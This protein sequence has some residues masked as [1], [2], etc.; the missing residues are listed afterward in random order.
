MNSPF[1]SPYPQTPTPG[2]SSNAL[3][4]GRPPLTSLKPFGYPAQQ[5]NINKQ[6][7][8]PTPHPLPRKPHPLTQVSIMNSTSHELS[9][10]SSHESSLD[11][12]LAEFERNQHKPSNQTNHHQ[13]RYSTHII[14]QPAT[15][16][17]DEEEEGQE[18]E[19]EEED[20]DMIEDED[21]TQIT[22]SLDEEVSNNTD[23][24]SL[25][26]GLSSLSPPGIGRFLPNHR[27]LSA[28]PMMDSHELED[29]LSSV[30]RDFSRD[31]SALSLS[32]IRR[33][34]APTPLRALEQNYQQFKPK[35]P[36]HKSPT[37]F[38][39]F[40][41]MAQELR[42]DLEKITGV[43]TDKPPI[44]SRD[45]NNKQANTLRGTLTS[46]GT[47]RARRVFGSDDQ[48]KSNRPHPAG[49]TSTP[50]NMRS[51]KPVAI[52]L[53][54]AA[55][56]PFKLNQNST[57]PSQSKPSI[58]VV[59]PSPKSHLH[60]QQQH[61]FMQYTSTNQ[62]G[63]LTAEAKKIVGNSVRV[64]DVTGLTDALRSP[65]KPEFHKA[66]RHNAKGSIDS[67]R[68]DAT[69]NQALTLLQHRLVGLENENVVCEEKIQDLE[70]QL[71]R[72]RLEKRDEPIPIGS[73]PPV[74]RMVQKLKVYTRKLNQSIESHAVALEE[75]NSFKTR[76]KHV[77]QE[78]GAVRTEV[79]QWSE[80][81]VEL[82]RGLE[83]LTSEVREIRSMIESVM[84]ARSLST[85][86][87][88][89][90]VSKVQANG[91]G[92]MMRP[93]GLSKTQQEVKRHQVPLKPRMPPARSHSELTL[94]NDRSGIEAWRSQASTPRSGNSFIGADEIAR[95]KK[96]VAEEQAMRTSTLG[97]SKPKPSTRPSQPI[98]KPLAQ[99]IPG[100]SKP[101]N[102]L[103]TRISSAPNPLTTSKSKKPTAPLK[104]SSMGGPI[105]IAQEMSRA[106]AILKNVP[107][108][109]NSTCSEC[110]KRKSQNGNGNPIRMSSA[111]IRLMNKEKGKVIG[112]E[113]GFRYENEGERESLEKDE[114]QTVLVKI[115]HEIETDFELHRKI[116]IELSETYSKMN[117]PGIGEDL[118]KRKVLGIHL[119]ESVDTLEKKAEQIHE[120]YRLLN[121]KDIKLS[122]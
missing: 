71:R 44:S 92:G 45:Q 75:L 55:V 100:P 19:E 25:R 110:R 121:F 36:N 23:S 64:P 104:T 48:L 62:D 107:T 60:P 12:D 85:S 109:D 97:P 4:Y 8:I 82:K 22:E 77:R 34:S 102:P 17:E 3:N 113:G 2:G 66:P 86:Q 30:A 120:L 18:E 52:P 80:E 117:Q 24:V 93:I 49:L 69:L 105:Q 27:R 90:K 114:P 57:R 84:Q 111:P 98:S 87:N 29:D 103:P 33:T 43:V 83:G 7:S 21:E 51:I 16:D 56:P 72:E 94:L 9:L 6:T 95:L 11:Q 32:P 58:Q 1:A 67:A 88:H 54:G 35:Q 15:E 13:T 28:A 70:A 5:S 31:L 101:N 119:K 115:I 42:R 37:P 76:H 20:E 74:E 116:F 79:R 96:Q 89:K 73:G 46:D 61:R 91:S 38:S 50:V 68:P 99:P 63:S 81:V 65:D 112:N 47:G 53:P 108:H 39:G 106:E 59:E 78:V 26:L 122:N 41:G 14:D 10:D 40:E 118:I